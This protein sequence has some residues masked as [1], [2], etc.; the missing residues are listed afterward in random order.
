[1]QFIE[2]GPARLVARD[3]IIL[4]PGAAG[5][6][7]KVH[8]GR[9]QWIHVTEGKTGNGRR[10]VGGRGGYAGQKEN[11]QPKQLVKTA[12]QFVHI[13]LSDAKN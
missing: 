3:G 12:N 11:C 7:I 10:R 9:D 8:A 2:G 13:G 1:L 5:V 6:V 4:E